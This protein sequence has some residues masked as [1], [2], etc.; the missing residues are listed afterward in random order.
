MVCLLQ[1]VPFTSHEMEIGMM[2]E[3]VNLACN[4]APAGRSD[5]GWND[6]SAAG[7][8]CPRLEGSDRG[9]KGLTVARRV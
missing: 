7:R 8:V 5:R 1:R 9:W 3:T 2:W 4:Q 6:T